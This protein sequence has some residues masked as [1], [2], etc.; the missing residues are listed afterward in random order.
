MLL[1]F[2]ASTA[3]C[4]MVANGKFGEHAQLLEQQAGGEWHFK[5]IIWL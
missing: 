4:F 2:G 3:D 1:N 5:S